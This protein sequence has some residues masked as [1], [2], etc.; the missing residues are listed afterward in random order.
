MT[1]IGSTLFF[2]APMNSSTGD[3]TNFTIYSSTDGGKHWSWY[4]GVY[5][6]SSGYSDVVALSDAYEQQLHLGVSFQVGHNLPHVEG[7]GY[8][9]AFSRVP[10]DR[11]ISSTTITTT[12]T[13][14]IIPSTCLHRKC[15]FVRAGADL[16]AARNAVRSHL[17][18]NSYSPGGVEIRLGPG[19]HVVPPGGLL[20]DHRDSGQEGSPVSWV[21]SPRGTVLD[22]RVRVTGFTK[23]DGAFNVWSAEAPAGKCLCIYLYL[24][25]HCMDMYLV[26]CFVYVAFTCM[27]FTTPPS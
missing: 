15:F 1:S 26:V 14:K 21:G 10:L 8:D 2:G 12:T 7:G 22:G 17:S 23:V 19:H 16:V 25:V 24:C 27:R 20:L 4:A 11:D 13:S 9:I 3:R 5:S 18:D 6:G